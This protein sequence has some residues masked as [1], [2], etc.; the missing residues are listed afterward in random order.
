MVTYGLGGCEIIDLSSIR[1]SSDDLTARTQDDKC[2]LFPKC[3]F[4]D[5]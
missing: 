5:V 4:D 1:A 3:W 2:V